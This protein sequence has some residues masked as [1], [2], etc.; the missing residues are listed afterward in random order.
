MFSQDGG[1][2]T[3]YKNNKWRGS[4][5]HKVQNEIPHWVG[6]TYKEYFKSAKLVEIEDEIVRVLDLA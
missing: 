3:T 1:W 5:W 2:D 6:K 4:M